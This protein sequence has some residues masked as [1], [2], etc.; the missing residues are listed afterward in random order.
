MPMLECLGGWVIRMRQLK[1]MILFFALSVVSGNS[2]Q[3]PNVVIIYADDLGYGEVNALNPERCKLATPAIDSLACDGMVFSDGHSSSAVCTPSR[4]SMLTGRYSWR[5]A[6]QKGVL[7]PWKPDLLK[8]ETITMPE[9]VRKKGYLTAAIGKWHLGWQWQKR[10]GQWV[11]DEPVRGGPVDHGYDYYFGPDVPDFPPFAWIENDRL[12][13]MP[14]ENS[15]P[16]PRGGRGGPLVPGWEPEAMLSTMA[17][18]ASE[19]FEKRAV[20]Q[21]PFFLY[22]GLTSP[23]T[24]IVPSKDWKGKSGMGAYCD[25]VLETD[26]TVGQVLQALEKSGLD[27]N[28]LVLFS[29][30]NGCSS[31]PSKS[32]KLAK[33]FGHYT[34]GNLR[35]HKGSSFEGGTRVP[36]IVRWPGVVP[37]GSVCDQMVCQIDYMATLADVLG[38]EMPAAAGVD[39]I[40]FLPLLKDPQTTPPRKTLIL[41]NYYG[42]FSLRQGSYKLILAP[43]N[44]QGFGGG[45]SDAEA[46]KNGD[47][48]VQLY[49]LETDLAETENLT[50]KQPERVQDMTEQLLKDIQR[51]RTTPGKSL[52]NDVEIDAY[53][54]HL[55]KG[56]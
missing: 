30:D 42:E 27:K 31:G 26:H 56:K 14:T 46:I 16:D 19:Y 33:E 51:G 36:F 15:K 39:S 49:H 40:S 32:I 4:Y 43:G 54:K 38:I 35:G 41:H 45:P 6:L 12:T 52:E 17:D 23:H 8:A 20:D 11:F 18:K 13:A 10:D 5:S 29:S 34:S 24:P 3:A 55:H 7:N 48:M 47:P 22:F 53:K 21:K 25:F 1:Y 2:E 37:A 50:K 44:G 28:T 9:L